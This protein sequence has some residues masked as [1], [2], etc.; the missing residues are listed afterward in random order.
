MAR[1]ILSQSG[2]PTLR[3][4]SC[5]CGENSGSLVSESKILRLEDVESSLREVRWQ[6]RLAEPE[7]PGA[8]EPGEESP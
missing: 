4:A 8:D 1:N 6:D 7:A 2:I 5:P 3:V